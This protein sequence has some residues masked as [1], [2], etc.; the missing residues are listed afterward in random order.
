MVTVHC[1][2]LELPKAL[3]YRNKK[4]CCHFAE[5][6]TLPQLC[7]AI[8]DSS[9]GSE[10]H[11]DGCTCI[12]FM[13]CKTVVVTAVSALYWW[14]SLDAIA[15]VQSTMPDVRIK[16]ADLGMWQSQADY[17]RRLR[18]VEVFAFPFESFPPHVRNLK[19]YAWKPLLVHMFL[20]QYEVVFYMDSSARL[21]CSLTHQLL[22]GLRNFPIRVQLNSFYDGSFTSDGTYE[23]LG[24]TRRRAGKCI[25]L[26]A[27]RLLFRNS[28]FLYQKIMSH[29]VDCALHEE[30]IAPPGSS[31][32]GC[33]M[34]KYYQRVQNIDKLEV[35]EN[36]GCHRFDQSVL[37]VL[38]GREFQCKNS[39]AEDINYSTSTAL[40]RYPTRCFTVF[41]N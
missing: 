5:S 28:S 13:A 34:V 26:D 33:D 38:L 10:S 24:V 2:G 30:C 12:D 20:L 36:I 11:V 35:V 41:L 14:N 19:T 27:N 16:V 37:T 39:P 1:S 7:G 32:Y 9:I 23:Y 3:P 8:N 40:W 18:N 15:S 21:K 6:K 29:F 25:Q 4:Q 22:D 31:P 17:M